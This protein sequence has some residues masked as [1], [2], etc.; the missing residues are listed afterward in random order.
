MRI[1]Y[2]TDTYPPQVNGVSVVTRLAVEGLSARGHQVGVVAPRYPSGGTV[3]DGVGSE[4][5]ATI[6]SIPLPRYPEARLAA[7]AFFKV[8]KAASRFRPDLV[9]S[10]TEFMLGRLGQ[11]VAR[12][13][14]VPLVTSYHTDF[15]R[16]MEAY[17]V[18]WL[19]EPIH[20][21]LSRF[22][23]R[24]DLTLTPSRAAAL[25]LV[26]MGVRRTIVWGA[27]VD[28]A[29][30]RPER[31]R[32]DLRR[33]LG[34]D[35]RFGFLHVGRLAPEKHVELVL[36]AYRRCVA[37]LG[38][39]RVRLVIAGD[40]PSRAALASGAPPGVVFLG[41]L[42]R[43]TELPD[44][45]ASMDGFL[46]SSETETLGLVVLEAMA[47]GLPVVATPAMGVGE[48][49]HHGVNGLQYPAGDV[50]TMAQ[51]MI[52]L[53]SDRDLRSSLAE[54][55]RQTALGLSW[56]S[57]LDRLERIY[58]NLLRARGRQPVLPRLSWRTRTLEM[59]T[60][61]MKTLEMKTLEMK[62]LEMET[63]EM[64]RGQSR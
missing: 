27:G 59:K 46:F 19:T 57:E 36:E 20:R 9:H 29:I 22:H 26:M 18:P 3:F 55:A 34:V 33:H 61:E 12:R 41:Y 54:G 63:V 51:L 60:L 39:D 11:L 49:L 45:Y 56:D 17:G 44:L 64:G 21:Y 14:R 2:L 37:T 32:P 50:E 8:V 25:Q 30:Y 58:A 1:L 40:G 5:L 28:P 35:R 13:H 10:A 53:V 6:P 23:N 38:E 24:A 42:D 48:H 7:P 52:R 15:G 62:T 43:K 31:R 16:Y 4:L 47:S